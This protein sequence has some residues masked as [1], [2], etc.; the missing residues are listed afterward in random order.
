MNRDTLTD[1][2]GRYGEAWI[3]RDPYKASLLFDENAIY[4]ETPFTDPLRGREDI[5]RYWQDVPRTQKDINFEFEIFSVDDN[6]GIIHWWASYTAI[7]SEAG[8]QLDGIMTITLDSKGLCRSF[9]EWWHRVE[10]PTDEP[11][12]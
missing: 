4:Q 8:V 12:E 6:M 11:V 2:L 5:Q 10:T 7:P 1:W 3:L 9:N